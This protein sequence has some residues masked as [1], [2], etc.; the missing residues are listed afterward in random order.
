MNIKVKR[1]DHTAKLPS[2]KHDDDFC[3]DLV[4]TKRRHIGLFLWEYETGLAMQIDRGIEPIE[5][6]NSLVYSGVDFN[7]SYIKLSLD[8]RPRSSIKDTGFVLCNS[9]GTIDEGYTGP[10][11][12]YFYHVLPWK[13]PYRVGDKIGQVKLGMSFPLQFCE[14]QELDKTARGDGGFG[15]TGK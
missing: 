13:R 5:S 2:Q 9:T 8:I 1:L 7:K 3:Y 14:V 15:S 11:K 4:A 10:I 6:T 12:L